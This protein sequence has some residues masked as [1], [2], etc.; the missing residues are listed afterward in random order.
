MSDSFLAR[1]SRRKRTQTTADVPP[2]EEAPATPRADPDAG[3]ARESAGAAPAPPQAFDPATL[4]PIE[5]I[6]A[7]TDIRPF[8]AAG[9]P[10]ELTRAALRRAWILDPKIRDFIGPADYDWDFNSPGAIAG[11][12]PIETDEVLRRELARLLSRAATEETVATPPPAR[13]EVLPEL[14]E[15]HDVRTGSALPEASK[16]APNRDQSSQPQ[17]SPPAD[18]EQ[19]KKTEELQQVGRRR[20]GGALPRSYQS[21]TPS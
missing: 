1:W 3:E 2:S 17:G 20:H 7:T 8:L 4:P 11:F 10:P 9:V 12:G 14:P 6:T 15:R 21:R 13:G 5:E 19:S 16:T 18:L